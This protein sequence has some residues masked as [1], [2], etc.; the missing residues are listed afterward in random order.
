M[1]NFRFFKISINIYHHDQRYRRATTS[2]T[3]RSTAYASMLRNASKCS[4]INIYDHDQRHCR[5]TTE[6]HCPS[7]TFERN[8]RLVQYFQPIHNEIVASMNVYDHDQRHRRPTTET[9]CPSGTFERNA[10]LDASESPWPGPVR[11]SAERLYATLRSKC[12]SVNARKHD[13]RLHSPK[14]VKASPPWVDWWTCNFS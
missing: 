11:P 10:R 3:L 6:T 4:S 8:A 5:P 7:G 2:A 1:R 9:H 13:Q 12:Q 14:N